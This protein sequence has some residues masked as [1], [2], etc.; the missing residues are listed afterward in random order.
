M[1]YLYELDLDLVRCLGH[2][3]QWFA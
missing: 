3:C 1:S 2:T